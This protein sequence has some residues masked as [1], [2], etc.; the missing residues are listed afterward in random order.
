MI[1]LGFKVR[2]KQSIDKKAM[3][4]GN[5]VAGPVDS[6]NGWDQRIA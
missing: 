2:Q 4:D 6:T 3:Q 5:E 1:E